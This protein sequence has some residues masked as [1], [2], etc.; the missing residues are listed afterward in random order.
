VRTIY[1]AAERVDGRKLAATVGFFDG[2]HAGHRSLIAQ[3]RE[4]AAERGLASAVFTFPVH[5]RRVLQADY[6]PQL[7]D[8]FEEKLARIGETGVDYCAV[9][10]FT[11]ALAR[12]TAREFI[13]RLAAEWGVSTLVVGYD[14]RF[15]RD[16]AE[17]FEAYVAHGRTVGMEVVH[18]VPYLLEDGTAVS[19][20]RIR[21]LLTECRVEEAA[22]MLTVPY[23][24]R[25]HVVGGQ[26]IGRTMGF[27]TANLS[28]DEPLKVLPGDGVYAVRAWLR[29]TAYRGMLSIGNRPTIDNRPTAVEVHLLGFSG[30]VYGE[31]LEVEFIRH[32]RANRRF[33]SLD[34]LREQLERDRETVAGLPIDGVGEAERC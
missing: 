31:A 16:R 30:D 5:P 22:R 7:L 10:D 14:H 20:S 1:D 2:V 4:A 9:L 6:R 34:A 33:D 27:P 3:L 18:G 15:G 8:T 25:G 11:P 28:V 26:Q 19:S 21:A 13:E 12:L 32:L 24:L 29:G 23:R 17:G